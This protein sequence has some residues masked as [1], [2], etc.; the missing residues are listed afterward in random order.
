[1][2]E[3]PWKR[4]H[5]LTDMSKAVSSQLV[6]VTNETDKNSVHGKRGRNRLAVVTA[7]GKV[8][9]VKEL[10][11]KGAQVDLADSGGNT[12]LMQAA[13]AGNKELAL[14]L[15]LHGADVT[16]RN[17][18]G[19]TALIEAC[20]NRQ[21]VGLIHPLIYQGACVDEANSDGMTPL[22]VA[23]QHSLLD[24]VKV[25]LDDGAQVSKVDKSC[26]TALMYA[27]QQENATVVKTL[28]AAGANVRAHNIKQEVAL[29][30]A[31]RRGNAQVV[32]TLIQH[33]AKPEAKNRRGENALLL[34]CVHG[35]TEVVEILASR[36]RDCP[37]TSDALLYATKKDLV[38]AIESLCAAGV[39]VNHVA[40]YGARVTPLI[41]ACQWAAPETLTT[42]IKCGADVNLVNRSRSGLRTGAT[43][44]L[45]LLSTSC[46]V[47]EREAKVKILLQHGADPNLG[48]TESPLER[49]ASRRFNFKD[50]IPHLFKAGA[51]TGRSVHLAIRYGH[52]DSVQ[53]LITNGAMPMSKDMSHSRGHTY[54][55]FSFSIHRGLLEV[56]R[57]FLSI[58]FLLPCDL[59]LN[60]NNMPTLTFMTEDQTNTVSSFVEDLCSQP[61]SLE[62]LSFGV[63]SSVL[64]FGKDRAS[65]VN[66]LGL[67]TE[68]KDKL[69]F[70]HRTAHIP[71]DKWGLI[72]V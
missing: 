23:S 67:P 11:L 60:Q 43:A 9:A 29:M 62:R 54:T 33:G 44:L 19:S 46:P 50:V 56:A 36:S 17:K 26:N 35:Q 69:M 2:D 4:T 27:C 42:L 30:V 51:C 49:A 64:G 1:M 37:G 25:L 66:F 21:G 5:H 71:V 38:E 13:R 58:N 8:N 34:A 57:F 52:L 6:D 53:T 28:I 45:S 39:D 72:E 3:T 31:A 70:R 18:K 24:I 59:K 32:R 16:H 20:T 65:K 48:S 47:P 68:Y 15:L 61:W 55:P 41:I 40:E 22:M 63:V 14:L 7:Q 12:P 10:L